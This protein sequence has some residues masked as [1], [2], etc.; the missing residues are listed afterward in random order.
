MQDKG[1]FQDQARPT[2]CWLVYSLGLSLLWGGEGWLQALD[3]LS[4]RG[5]LGSKG[6]HGRW[7]TSSNLTIR[8]IS[9]PR[10]APLALAAT[11][12]QSQGERHQTRHQNVPSMVGGNGGGENA[13]V[14]LK[15]PAGVDGWSMSQ[16]GHQLRKGIWSESSGRAPPGGQR[17]YCLRRREFALFYQEKD[18]WW[19]R[20][21]RERKRERETCATTYLTDLLSFSDLKIFTSFF[22]KMQY[23]LS[24]V[25]VSGLITL[26][27]M[28]RAEKSSRERFVCQGG[29]GV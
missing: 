25:M 17:Q 14:S 3:V 8:F 2:A 1:W 5:L 23:W 15:V 27:E 19:G 4:L 24:K 11:V 21:G 7:L 13:L 28:H 10:L 9:P 12:P 22:Q 29:A 26:P 16:S 20:A 6:A 18:S